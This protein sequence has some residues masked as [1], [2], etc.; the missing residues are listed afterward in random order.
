MEREATGLALPPARPSAVTTS[1]AKRALDCVSA[2]A[3]LVL[4]SPVLVVVAAWVAIEEGR[5]VLFVQERTGLDGRPFRM[6]KLRTM[7]NDAISVGQQSGLTVEDPYGLVEDDA[8]ITRSGRLLRRTSL[9]ELPQFWNVLRGEMGLVGPRPDIPEQSCHYTADDRRRL[10]AKPGMTGW[11]QVNG[12]D[13]LPW[14]ERYLLDAWY[15]DHWSFWFDLKILLRTALSLG[16][17]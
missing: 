7:I 3:G 16:G 10:E 13:T 14:P 12:R 1:R 17:R 2:A 8:R 11:A 5:Q 15:I 4:A 6:Y 9:D